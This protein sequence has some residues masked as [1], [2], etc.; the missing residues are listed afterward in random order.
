LDQRALEYE[1]IRKKVVDRNSDDRGVTNDYT[2]FPPYLQGAARL[3]VSIGPIACF[4]K[5]LFA[6]GTGVPPDRVD[7]RFNQ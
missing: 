1:V 7:L 2:I 3:K 5:I 6:Q 4:D